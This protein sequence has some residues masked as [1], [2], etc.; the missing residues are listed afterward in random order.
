LSASQV[1]GDLTTESFDDD[2]AVE[3]TVGAGEEA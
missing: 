3:E 2:V 1:E